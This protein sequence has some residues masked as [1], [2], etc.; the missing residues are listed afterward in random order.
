MR[1]SAGSISGFGHR[2]PSPRCGGTG[3]AHAKPVEITDGISKESRPDT[4]VQC[5]GRVSVAELFSAYGILTS[6]PS[7]LIV[8]I[9][10]TVIIHQLDINDIFYNIGWLSV[11]T[12][13]EPLLGISVACFPMS[14]SLLLSMYKQATSFGSSAFGHLSRATSVRGI[15]PPG[16]GSHRF[17]SKPKYSTS[18]TSVERLYD[19]LYPMGDIG[20]AASCEAQP[21]N[22]SREDDLQ[23]SHGI[24]VTESWKVTSHNNTSRGAD[25]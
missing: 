2:K 23:N 6:H 18:D 13:L 12:N 16:S 10:R 25:S 15:Q 17:S 7:I 5:R 9:W 20:T 22:D 14:R 11:C 4:H 19:R 3:V 1:Q 8:S 24:Q 21:V